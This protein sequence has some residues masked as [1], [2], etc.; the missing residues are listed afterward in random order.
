MRIAHIISSI[1]LFSGGPPIVAGA[2][3]STLASIGHEVT[4]IGGRT[5]RGNKKEQ[6]AI[7]DLP[8]IE[9]VNVIEYS[10]NNH[11][12]E[13]MLNDKVFDLLMQAGPFDIVHFPNFEISASL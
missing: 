12:L 13:R 8:G 7:A 2:L 4:L 6:S 9:N 5:N 11:K 10:V 1:E 3:A